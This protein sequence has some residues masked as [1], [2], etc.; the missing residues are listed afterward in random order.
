MP[1]DGV[2]NWMLKQNDVYN[3]VAYNDLRASDMHENPH[4]INVKNEN[5]PEN[6]SGHDMVYM[7]IQENGEH[8]LFKS[9]MTFKNIDADAVFIYLMSNGSR[10][11]GEFQQHYNIQHEENDIDVPLQEFEFCQLEKI[12]DYEDIIHLRHMKSLYVFPSWTE[13]RDYCLH[14]SWSV[15][16]DGSYT[17]LLKPVSLIFLALLLIS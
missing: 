11:V 15:E 13:R 2:S 9:E 7:S 14:R 16:Q 4:S 17:I 1:E 3:G 6:D 10:T 8:A 12:N 5:E